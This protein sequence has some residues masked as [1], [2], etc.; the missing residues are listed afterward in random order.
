MLHAKPMTS[1]MATSLKLFKF[2]VP[3]FD[4]ITLYRSLVG[5]L[6]YLSFTLLDISFSV[7]K[8]SQFL[9]APQAT[10]WSAIKR[11]L[12]Y[13]KATIKH[14]LLFQLQ[15]TNT[16]QVYSNADWGDALMIVD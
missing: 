11:I 7:N 14:G 15:S 2:D 9:H 1:P 16:L 3:D 12:R 4:D 5:G 6:Q 10:H 8:V 13:L